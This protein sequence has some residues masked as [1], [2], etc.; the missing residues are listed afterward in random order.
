LKRGGWHESDYGAA[1][2]ARKTLRNFL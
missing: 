2:S 1:L